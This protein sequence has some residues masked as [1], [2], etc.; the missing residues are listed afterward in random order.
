[1]PTDKRDDVVSLIYDAAVD[2]ARWAEALKGIAD[3]TRSQQVLLQSYDV[4]GDHIA[5]IAPLT[6]PY[7]SALWR[8]QFGASTQWRRK[9]MQFAVGQLFM[10]EDYMSS[11]ALAALPAYRDW[12]RPQGMGTQILSANVLRDGPASAVLQVHKR[13]GEGF[14]SEDRQA[15]SGLVSHMVRALAIHRRLH[16]AE[17]GP[18]GAGDCAPGGFAILDREAN[19]LLAAET[20]LEWLAAAGLLA[21]CARRPSLRT[22]DRS[23]ERWLASKTA[24]APGALAYRT[25]AGQRLRI[26][27]V[28]LAEGAGENGRWLATD[29]PAALLH[30]ADPDSERRASVDR[31]VRAHGL[32]PAEAAVA[33]EISRGDGRRAAAARLGIHETTVRSHLSAVFEKVGVHRQAELTRLVAQSAG[34][35]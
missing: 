20:T 19:I 8:E 11:E 31:L 32:T 27:I 5:G 9:R 17:L 15:M 4:A 24:L 16:L 3:L 2:G 7:W 22:P 23:I 35:G 6:D 25:A 21:A 29:R 28:P 13:K 12:W 30:V 10:I 34:V 1:M 18:R 33:L 26:T 14:S